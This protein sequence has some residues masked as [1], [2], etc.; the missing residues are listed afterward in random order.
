MHDLKRAMMSA[1][2]GM[3]AQSHR[4][5][6]IGENVA[7]ADTPGYHRKTVSFETQLDRVSR[8]AQ[9]SPGPV[10]LDGTAPRQ[11]FEPGH[12]L[13]DQDGMLTLSNVDPLIELAD[14]REAQR[15]YEANLNIFDQARRMAGSML[16][17]LRR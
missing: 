10:R 14:A 11:V 8:A 5:R 12:P 17:L 4:L 15:S 13:A 16:D 6:L 3:S 2:S 9:V 7:N 1:A